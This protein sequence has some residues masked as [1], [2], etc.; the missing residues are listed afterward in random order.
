MDETELL[1][2]AAKTVAAIWCLRVAAVMREAAEDPELPDAYRA[3]WAGWAAR[4]A[5][6][7]MALGHGDG[8]PS[9]RR[10]W[11]RRRGR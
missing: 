1:E 10:S 4:L 5:G 7:A 8:V 2:P 11:W 6:H 3:Q 9:V